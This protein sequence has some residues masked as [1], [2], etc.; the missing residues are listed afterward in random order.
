MFSFRAPTDYQPGDVSPAE[1][2][3]YFDG[4]R[5]NLEDLGNPIFSR[6]SVGETGTSTELSGYSVISAGSLEQALELAAG[7]P[8]ITLGGGVE[9]GEITP[10]DPAAMQSAGE[11]AVA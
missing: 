8:L 9:V 7:C 4:V 11:S 10:L 5:S 1:W 3:S 6:R 2:M